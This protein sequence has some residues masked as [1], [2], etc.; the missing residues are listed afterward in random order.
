MPD[1]KPK[2]EPKMTVKPMIDLL[3]TFTGMIEMFPLKFLQ[4]TSANKSRPFAMG[5]IALPNNIVF[6]NPKDVARWVYITLAIPR[7]QY[8]EYLKKQKEALDLSKMEV[9]K[10][11]EN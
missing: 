6:T 11:E 9:Q 5:T 7:H 10:N 8:L 4:V 2:H 1:E 3:N